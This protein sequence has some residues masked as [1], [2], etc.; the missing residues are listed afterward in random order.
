M[1]N[2]ISKTAQN[3]KRAETIVQQTQPWNPRT[4][5]ALRVRKWFEKGARPFALTFGSA[6]KQIAR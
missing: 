2:S 5:S 3:G 1:K 6:Q 4:C